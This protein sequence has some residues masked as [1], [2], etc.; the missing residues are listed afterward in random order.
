MGHSWGGGVAAELARVDD[1]VKA[2][3]LLD[4]YLQNADDLTRLGLSKPFLGMYNPSGG[5]ERTLYNHPATVAAVWF[6]IN[7]SV[8]AQF[9]DPFSDGYWLTSLNTLKEWREVSRTINA[10][11]LWFLNKYLKEQDVPMPQ[12]KDYP[13]ITGFRQK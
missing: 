8:H 1:R 9:S 6:I 3:V 2:A 5:G 4:A 11:T 10:Y 12:L 7:P 13:R